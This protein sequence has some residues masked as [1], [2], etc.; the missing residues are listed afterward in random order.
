MGYFKGMFI[1]SNKKMVQQN[2][3]FPHHVTFAV[4]NGLKNM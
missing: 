3:A 2:T 4:Q 1:H